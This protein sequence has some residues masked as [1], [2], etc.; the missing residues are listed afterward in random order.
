MIFISGIQ[1]HSSDDYDSATKAENL[2][3]WKT[4]PSKLDGEW[5]A[6]HSKTGVGFVFDLGKIQNFQNILLVNTNNWARATK[7]FKV[8]VS[9]DLESWTEVLSS[10][11]P[12]TRRIDPV[13]PNMFCIQPTSARFVR[14]ELVS[15]WGTFGLLFTALLTS[16]LNVP[17]LSNI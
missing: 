13:P 6:T 3:T 4:S 5:L 8:F 12:D 11:L 9:N 10:S 16:P 7:A 14:F 15:Y 17:F 1:V 2:L